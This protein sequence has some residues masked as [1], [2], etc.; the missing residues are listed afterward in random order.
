MMTIPLVLV[1]AYFIPAIICLHYAAITSIRRYRE[2]VLERAQ[3]IRKLD[4]YISESV[5]YHARLEQAEALATAN[6]FAKKALGYG[7]LHKYFN[8]SVKYPR[9]PVSPC[10]SLYWNDIFSSV[11]VAFI[12]LANIVLIFFVLIDSFKAWFACI[13]K[14]VVKIKEVSHV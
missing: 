8:V 2:D 5:T 9:L 6:V 13:K 1:L 7:S 3:Y 11:L 4:E 10:F 12:P 14:P